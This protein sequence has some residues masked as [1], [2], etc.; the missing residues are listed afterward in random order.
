MRHRA[1]LVNTVAS[2]G[3]VDK[4]RT[5]AIP[6]ATDTKTSVFDVVSTITESDLYVFVRAS[7]IWI[8]IVFAD[9]Y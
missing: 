8:S 6:F 7:S 1:T 4:P 5:V 3:I 2:V 9:R